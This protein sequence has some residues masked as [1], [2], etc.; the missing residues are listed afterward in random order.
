MRVK[1]EP[2]K[3]IWNRNTSLSR[4]L[5]A[6]SFRFSKSRDL[7]RNGAIWVLW[8]K[9]QKRIKQSHVMAASKQAGLVDVKIVSFSE[10]LSGLKLMI[11]VARR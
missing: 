11:P 5:F 1:K 10:R 7:K 6:S 9:G 8:P 4:V 2:E 3:P